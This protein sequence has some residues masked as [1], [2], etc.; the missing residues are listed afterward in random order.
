MISLTRRP[1]FRRPLSGRVAQISMPW[2]NAGAPHLAFEMWVLSLSVLKKWVP[3]PCEAR[4]GSD[5][6]QTN[7]VILSE[8]KD[9]AGGPFK[10]SVGLSGV[11]LSFNSK[12][13][14]ADSPTA[15]SP[16]GW[17][18]SRAL[19]KFGCPCPA[20]GGS[21]FQPTKWVPILAKQGRVQIPQTKTV[22]LRRAKRKI[23]SCVSANRFSANRFLANRPL[24]NRFLANRSLAALS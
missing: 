11:V 9:P 8:T 6:S 5:F 10:P 23:R 22:I 12:G 20:L 13:D 4:V 18:R 7:N 16:T 19:N 2:A 15:F 24:A 3:H 21:L 1:L 14:L 17:P